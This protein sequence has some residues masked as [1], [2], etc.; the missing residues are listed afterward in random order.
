MLAL[1]CA[2]SLAPAPQDPGP[3]PTRAEMRAHLV[4][5]KAVEPV[6]DVSDA[7]F[8][9][10]LDPAVPGVATAVARA[11]AGDFDGAWRSFDDW[12]RTGW[13]PAAG[14]RGLDRRNLSPAADGRVARAERMLTGALT[15]GPLEVDL[16]APMDWTQGAGMNAYS[17]LHSW[18]WSRDL[19]EHHLRTEDGRAAALLARLFDSWYTQRERITAVSDFD[20]VWY[21]LA[22]SGRVVGWSK[23]LWIL[24]DRDELGLATRQ[25]VMRMILASARHADRQQACGY[26]A[27]NW[28]VAG[29]GSL[30][31]LGLMWPVFREA[32]DWRAVGRR[33]LLEHV[34]WDHD[35]DGGHS[36]RTWGYAMG[37]VSAYHRLLAHL[38]EDPGGAGAI[39]WAEARVRERELWFLELVAPN[40]HMP[41]VHDSSSADL[42]SFLVLLAA[43]SG[44]G[45]FHWPIRERESTPTE[46][47]ARR[48]EFESVHLAGSGFTVLRDGQETGSGWLLV[49]WGRWAGSHIHHAVLDLNAYA[50][51]V[52]LLVEGGSLGYDHPL[53][54]WLRT[55]AAHNML[56]IE[57]HELGDGRRGAKVPRYRDGDGVDYFEGYHDGW[58]EAVG[59]R[60]RRRV[61][62][63]ASEYWLVVDTVEGAVVGEPA[64]A[65]HWHA[66]RPFRRA[67]ASLVSGDGPG[68]ELLS[69]A[70]A[71]VELAVDYEDEDELYRDRYRAVL[72]RP[73]RAGTCFVTV[74]APFADD[75]VGGAVEL[76]STAYGYRV[77]VELGERRDHVL[78]RTIDGAEPV[79]DEL[80]TDGALAWVREGT[81]RAA[82]VDGSHVSWRGEPRI[83]L[84]GAR[85]IA[86]AP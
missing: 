15:V 48:P 35:E 68:V 72:R 66:P 11:D 1:A 9:A 3:P 64:A 30:H 32:K 38:R 46:P 71:T 52:P 7:D 20:A 17:H 34:A 78:L 81:G 67:G 42:A 21:E 18:R 65:L 70:G 79:G 77:R 26:T 43:S 27:G 83:A 31:E 10:A 22:V 60:V 57:G 49:N 84:E 62:A 45:R 53:D 58:R 59:A 63:V 39:E 6:P 86:V 47:V 85:P 28:Q 16:A 50:L 13:E 2:L 33:R 69:N 80:V 8:F 23:L 61:L 36:E 12:L 44:D 5:K 14:L 24:R 73:A 75:P 25:V 54:P 29:A 19:S 56:V 40:G 82:V 76:A 37:I 74:V 55:P 4:A 41:G 51:G